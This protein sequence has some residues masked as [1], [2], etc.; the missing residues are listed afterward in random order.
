MLLVSLRKLR[1]YL[2]VL[3]GG[4]MK[5][6]PTRDWQ[7]EGRGWVYMAIIL[8]GFPALFFFCVFFSHMDRLD[9]SLSLVY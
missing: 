2:Y 8:L 5:T 6:K 1:F 9:S 4:T 7:K 3:I